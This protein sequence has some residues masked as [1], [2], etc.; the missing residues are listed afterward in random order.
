LIT[1]RTT[2][3]LEVL[4]KRSNFGQRVGFQAAPIDMPRSVRRFLEH[5][6]P[7]AGLF[8]ESELWPNLIIDAGSHYHIPLALVNGR[9][10][11]RSFRLWS[12]FPLRTLAKQLLFNFQL[13]LAQ[14]EEDASRFKCLAGVHCEYIGNLKSV[15]IPLP[16]A[17]DELD[18]AQKFIGSRKVWMTASTHHGEE[19]MIGFVH[20]AVKESFPSLLTVIMPRHPKRS[21]TIIQLLRKQF[22]LSCSLHSSMIDALRSGTFSSWLEINENHSIHLV[23]TFGDASLWYSLSDVCFIGGS[24]VAGTGGHSPSEASGFGLHVLFGPY[25]ENNVSLFDK[26]ISEDK[27]TKVSNRDELKWAL[28]SHLNLIQNIIHNKNN[29][30]DDFTI[31]EVG[32]GALQRVPRIRNTLSPCNGVSTVSS[33]WIYLQTFNNSLF[34]NREI[35]HENNFV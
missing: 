31:G 28:L 12:C 32:I 11:L 34:L 9:L 21:S 30:N 19:E 16:I 25:V 22:K 18:A 14:S 3:A 20:C 13:R 29:C 7:I 26:L 17:S 2:S 24:L 1:T 5:W 4:S 6:R 8:V 35:S 33:I 27:A 23:D 15:S 10:S